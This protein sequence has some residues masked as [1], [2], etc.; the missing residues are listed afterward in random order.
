MKLLTSFLAGK[1]PLWKAFVLGLIINFT[2]G[3]S[4][5]LLIQATPGNLLLHQTSYVSGLFISVLAWVGQWRC[6]FNTK[7][8]YLGAL[9]RVWLLVGVVAAIG[10]L[11]PVLPNWVRSSVGVLVLG[12]LVFGFAYYFISPVRDFIRLE[13]YKR[14]S[15]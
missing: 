12:L 8:F 9:L 7:Y 11:L 10:N 13:I 14:K 5:V 1:E 4:L 6:A 2:L 3:F 15:K